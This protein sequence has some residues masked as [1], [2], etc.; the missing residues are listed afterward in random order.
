MHCLMEAISRYREST[1]TVVSKKNWN[2][3]DDKGESMMHALYIL[4]LIKRHTSVKKS[5][6]SYI[7]CG[8]TLG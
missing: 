1:S 5:S 2:T 4:Q 8:V 6:A 3:K 7:H